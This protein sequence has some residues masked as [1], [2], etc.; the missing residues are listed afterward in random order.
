MVNYE[1]FDKMGNREELD[2]VLIKKLGKRPCPY[3]EMMDFFR[4]NMHLCDSLDHLI[5]QGIVEERFRDG[6][7]FYGLKKEFRES[8]TTKER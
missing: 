5:G 3:K 7:K 4:V 1:E 6:E 2:N 8:L